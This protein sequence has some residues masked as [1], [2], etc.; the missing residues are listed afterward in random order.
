MCPGNNVSTDLFDISSSITVVKQRLASSSL[1]VVK[2]RLANIE[3][4]LLEMIE[5]METNE[6]H[7]SDNAGIRIYHGWCIFSIIAVATGY[8]G[9]L[10][11]D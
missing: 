3:K 1:T 4:T 11:W 6:M 10:K 9:A 8:K 7:P 5:R 2:L